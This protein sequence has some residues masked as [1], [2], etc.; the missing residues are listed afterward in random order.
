MPWF[1]RP[2]HQI[3]FPRSFLKMGGRAL[4]LALFLPLQ[5]EINDLGL[6]FPAIY[7]FGKRFLPYSIQ[8]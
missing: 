2:G 4:N 8:I 3:I 6:V 1:A 7:F 5:T